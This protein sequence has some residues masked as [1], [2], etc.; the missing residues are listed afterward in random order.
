MGSLER[1]PGGGDNW[2]EKVGGLDPYLEKIAESIHERTGKTISQSIQIAWGMVRKWAAGGDNV[3]PDTRAKAAKAA[4]NMEAKRA[5]YKAMKATDL[6]APGDPGEQL[7]LLLSAEVLDLAYGDHKPP[8]DWKHGYKPISPQAMRVKAKKE[9]SPNSGKRRRVAGEAPSK[10][11]TPAQAKAADDESRGRGVVG[12]DT[13]PTPAK[14]EAP[15]YSTTRDATLSQ[16]ISSLERAITRTPQEEADLKEAKAE[17]KRRASGPDRNGPGATRQDR[18]GGNDPVGSQDGPGSAV[19]RASGVATTGDPRSPETQAS[20]RERMVRAMSD[21]ELNKE[22]NKRTITP[23]NKRAVQIELRR[24]SDAASEQARENGRKRIAAQQASREAQAKSDAARAARPPESRDAAMRRQSAEQD[25]RE[26]E[27]R[28]TPGITADTAGRMS[29]AQLEQTLDRLAE[30]G[31][32]SSPAFKAVEAEQRK[33][34]DAKA[35]A[36]SAEGNRPRR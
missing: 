27:Q 12:A 24:R 25:A 3:N 28:R 31:D 19:R 23:E 21:A 17:Q 2:L 30:A 35:A 26:R 34:E 15:D 4:A 1:N 32:F 13:G 14:V 5:R 8:Y 22:L 16:R 7:D 20:D 33:R 36:R 18:P 6:A 11:R 29:D 9:K 10:G